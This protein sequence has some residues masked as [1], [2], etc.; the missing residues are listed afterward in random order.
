MSTL[1]CGRELKMDNGCIAITSGVALKNNRGKS[2]SVGR[3]VSG[4]PG[5]PL[6]LKG[7]VA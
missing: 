7:E 2:F 6:Y 1:V 3:V 4:A 5:H